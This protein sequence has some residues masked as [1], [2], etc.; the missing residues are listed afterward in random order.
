MTHYLWM[1]DVDGQF[2]DLP[3]IHELAADEYDVDSPTIAMIHRYIATHGLEPV[4]TC[5]QCEAPIADDA[6]LPLCQS[7]EETARAT[8]RAFPEGP[9]QFKAGLR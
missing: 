1:S 3:A 7:C 9:E 5:N 6:T 2:L 4:E 8:A